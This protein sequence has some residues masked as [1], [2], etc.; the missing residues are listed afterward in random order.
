MELK[1]TCKNIW[2]LKILD[3]NYVFICDDYYLMGFIYGNNLQ[4]EFNHS[5]DELIIEV[6]NYQNEII[7]VLTKKKAYFFDF[8]NK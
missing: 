3:K 5:F 2:N 6:F 7:C 4:E 1:I 8:L